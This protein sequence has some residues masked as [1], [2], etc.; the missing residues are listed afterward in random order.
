MT[1]APETTRLGWIGTGVMGA[2]MAGHLL[3]A[4]Y[5]MTVFTRSREKAAELEAGGAAW[6]DTPAAVAAGRWPWVE[7]WPMRMR[8]KANRGI[9]H[10]PCSY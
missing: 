8:T 6:A 2:S 1:L 5:P 7:Q 10:T 3:A 4:G 9:I